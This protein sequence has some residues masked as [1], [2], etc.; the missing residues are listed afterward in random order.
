MA[1]WRRRDGAREA[2]LGARGAAP[3]QSPSSGLRVLIAFGLAVGAALKV[4]PGLVLA[5]QRDGTRRKLRNAGA[6][7]PVGEIPPPDGGWFDGQQMGSCVVKRFVDEMVGERWM[8]WYSARS[9]GFGADQNLVSTPTGR[10]GL[11]QSTDGIVWERLAGDESAGSCLAPN[12]ESWWA[13]DTTH[14]GVGDVHVRSS[15]MVQNSMGLYWMYYFGGNAEEQPQPGGAPPTTGG[16]MSIG[17]CLSNDGVHWGRVEGE[18]PSGALLEPLDGQTFVGWP[19]V[20]QMSESPEE[21]VLWYHARDEKDGQVAIGAAASANCIEWEHRGY[22]LTPGAAGAFDEA[23][24]YA[25]CVVRDPASPAR[26]SGKGWLM[27]YEGSD[28]DGRA[29]IGL[30]R[31]DDGLVWERTSSSPVLEPPAEPS[32]WDGG[33]VMTP[34]VVPLDDGSARM[35]YVGRALSGARGIGM[36]ASDGADWTRWTRCEAPPAVP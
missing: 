14:V 20:E 8:M 34:W 29:A 10:V 16:T 9:D 22:C 33:G 32:A 17:L 24:V 6:P 3:E 19:Q 13:F 1:N 12:D 2:R 26:G 21:W 36:A 25:R 5:P 15:D 23:S 18:H 7:V 27:Y 35:Y 11:A 30:A 4:G 31:S 28:A